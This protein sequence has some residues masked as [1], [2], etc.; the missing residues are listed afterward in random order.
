MQRFL[1]WCRR[2]RTVL[3]GLAAALAAALIAAWAGYDL[4]LRVDDIPVYK[5]VN[6]EYSQTVQLTEEGLSQMLPVE[7]GQTLYGVRLKFTNNDRIFFSGAIKAELYRGQ[8][9]LE[10]TGMSIFGLLDNTFYPLIFTEPFT[11]KETELLELRLNFAVPSDARNYSLGIWASEGQVGEM[12]LSAGGRALDAT[13][14]VQYVTDYSGSWSH[15]L[16]WALGVLVFLAV[17]GGFVMLFGPLR[18]GAR[19]AAVTAAAALLLG[20]AFSVVTPPLVAPDEY[21]HLAAAYAQASLRLGQ[22]AFDA[23]NRLY[24]R[25]ADAPYFG[26]RTGEI[27]IFAYKTYLEHLGDTGVPAAADTVSEAVYQKVNPALY[28]GQTAGIMLARALGRGF[29][30]ML[31]LGRLGNLLLYTALAAAAVIIVPERWKGLFACAA[32]L[33]MPLQLAASLSTDASILGLLFAYTAFCLLLRERPGGLGG[34]VTLV[35][36]TA[37]VAPLKA[38]YLPAA[39]L[40]LLVPAEHLDPRRAPKGPTV[41]LLR[42]PVRPGVLIKAGALAAAAALWCLANMGALLYATRDVDSAGLTRGFLVLLAG[43]AALGLVY[44]WLHRHPRWYKWFWRGVAAVLAVVVPVVLWRITHMW[45]GLSTD[46]LV[47]RLPNGDAAYNYTIGYI[48]RNVPGTVKLL[49]RS[50]AEQGGHWLQGLLGTTLGEPIVYRI[51]VS[52]LLGVGLVLALLAAALPRAGQRETLGTRARWGMCGIVLCVV[53][54][55][56][57]AALSWTPIN[58]MTVFG[59]Q[60]RYWL[61]VLPLALLS[62]TETRALAA[63]KDLAR[64]AVFAVL[65][66]TSLTLLQGYGLYAAWQPAA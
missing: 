4:A 54:L 27:G 55:S 31:L 22:P 3:L 57:A 30:A 47:E 15:R 5:I 49:L 51:D 16:S 64:P 40:C 14:A 17:A 56:V 42:R 34:A 59:L 10:T 6:D 20:G 48:C 29:H 37:A 26:T 28:L 50:A 63:Q 12:A 62:L 13:A 9:L 19:L 1:A 44:W 25:A 32:L 2:H 23:E 11:P 52:W 18:D 65:C 35:I 45:G 39:L 33:P 66:L 43:A 58:Y 60:G 38:I 41:R 21:T 53:G 7:A 8:T 61:P 24:V 36:L 46:Q